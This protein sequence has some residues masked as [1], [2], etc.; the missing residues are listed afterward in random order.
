[1]ADEAALRD[2]LRAVGLVIGAEDF[3]RVLPV[4]E[5]NLPR[6]A[7]LRA[8]R[9]GLD[10]APH[11]AAPDRTEAVLR[12]PARQKVLTGST[13]TLDLC[14][15]DLVEQAELLRRRKLSA[16][17]LTSAYLDRMNRHDPFLRA[18]V[19]VAE[20]T[21]DE[22]RRADR[23]I[24]A[25]K[26]RSALHGV[27]V[28]IKDHIAVAGLR[29][30][31]GSRLFAEHWPA[32]DAA[33]TARLREA[34]AIIIG[35]NTMHEF[36]AGPAL[37]DGDL[38]TGRNP[39]DPSRIP[40]GSS[41]GSAVAVAAGLCSA[42][43]GTDSAGS[44][45]IPAAYCGVV[46]LKPSYGWISREGVAPYCW[47]LDTPGILA[48]G[49][50]DGAAMF[51]AMTGH[52]IQD[53]EAGVRGMRIGVLRRY[54]LDA[55]DIRDDVRAATGAA[56]ALLRRLGAKLVTIDIPSVDRNDAIY[57]TFCA[58]AY[59]LHAGNLR[60]RAGAYSD[61]FRTQLY[62]AATATADDLL[63]ARRLQGRMLREA[64]AAL[65][66]VDALILPG[67][68]EPA[69]PFGSSFRPALTQAR[70]RFTRPWN[71]TG[72]PAIAVPCGF[73]QEGLPLSL[74][75]VGRPFDEATVLRVARAYER[76]TNWRH[77]RPDS[78]KWR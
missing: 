76:E 2:E 13:G 40:G 78:S 62:A 49:V 48:R 17:E 16:R 71:I 65:G 70:T 44:V 29:M 60:E 19:S 4:W 33:A 21:M 68:A 64:L 67:Q 8:E 18:Y 52:A 66:K 46:G 9:F 56:F 42:A 22:A 23:E 43:L 53:L 10:E 32:R 72:L 12:Q 6:R 20:R 37:P 11:M 3:A 74:Q 63:R 69:T 47:S 15:L 45:R 5:E 77:R 28:A 25:G 31:C 1:M 51:G 14:E 58:E 38:A 57:T 30:T 34:G 41:S 59:A 36:G 50:R 24:K 35:T 39:W 54:F 27:P 61:W 75:I 55:P 73:S 26:I 7:A